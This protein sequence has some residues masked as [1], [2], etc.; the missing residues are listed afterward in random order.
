MSRWGRVPSAFALDRVSIE[1]TNRCGKACAF[2]YNTSHPAGDTVWEPD[3]VVAF[4]D[5]LAANGVRAVSFGGGEPLEYPGLF[6][7][8]TRLRGRLFRSLTTNGLLLDDQLEPL[9]SAAPDKV[10]VSLHAPGSL[11]ERT[12]V[13]RQ[14][15]LLADRGIPS[16]VNLLV[17]WSRLAEA[18][19]AARQIADAGIG[20]DRVTYLPMRGSEEARF[21]SMSCLL[22]C[23]A[24]PRFAAIDWAGRAAWCSY[25]E[26]RR[27]LPSRD[28]AGLLA[29]LD[30]LR[31]RTC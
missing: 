2:C 3:E 30:G 18:A 27:P 5:D 4:V 24:S 10:H 19:E 17:A 22:G 13:I 31:L 26:S 7:V 16:G 1:L 20:G 6:T 28:H 15:R 14:V 11:P 29:A 9:V 25:T 21:Q 12:R 8:L 23:A